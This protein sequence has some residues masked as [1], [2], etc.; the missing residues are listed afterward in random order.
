MQSQRHKLDIATNKIRHDRQT[1]A[2]RMQDDYGI[3]LAAASEAAAATEEVGDSRRGRSRKL[4]SC[5]TSSISW[6]Q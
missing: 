6:A 1:L 2:E 5:G 4:P 3:D